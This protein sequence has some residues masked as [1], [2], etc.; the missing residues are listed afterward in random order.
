MECSKKI[1]VTLN[2]ENNKL[3][4]TDELDFELACVNS[5]TGRCPCPCFYAQDPGCAC[6]D[7]RRTIKVSV[8]KTPVYAVYPLSQPRMFNGRPYEVRGAVGEAAPAP[9]FGRA[10]AAH[11]AS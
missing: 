10:G 2:L 4:E 6:R 8:T 7:L 11:V 9:E 3:Y 1:V 5:P